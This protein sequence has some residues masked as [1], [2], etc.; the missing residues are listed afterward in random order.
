MDMYIQIIYQNN[1]TKHL[2]FFEEGEYTVIKT[3]KM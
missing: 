1:V 3:L 2:A